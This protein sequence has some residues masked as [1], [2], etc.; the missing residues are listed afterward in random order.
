MHSFCLRLRS[1]FPPSLLPL[2]LPSLTLTLF[3]SLPPSIL[4]L[5]SYIEE[6]NGKL[7]RVGGFTHLNLFHF[8]GKML[9][10]AL[11]EVRTYQTSH[12]TPHCLFI[13]IHSLLVLSLITLDL[14]NE[15]EISHNMTLSEFSRLYC[16]NYILL[17][18]NAKGTFLLFQYLISVP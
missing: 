15:V 2:F 18:Y 8:L 10:K 17:H 12:H 16:D 1:S 9:G 13:Y 11:Y 4:G 14:N 7:R 3:S 6:D 5:V